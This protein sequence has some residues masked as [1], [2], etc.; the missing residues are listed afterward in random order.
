MLD[1]YG[2]VLPGWEAANS[3]LYPAE[4]GTFRVSWGDGLDGISGQK[5]AAGGVVQHVTKIRFTLNNAT[6]YGL[7][8]GTEG[9]SPET[10]R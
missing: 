5:S 2:Q 9:S 7:S 3:Q 4:R 6:L 8:I 10:T 1:V